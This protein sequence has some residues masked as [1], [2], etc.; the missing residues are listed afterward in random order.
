MQAA[1]G[2]A[3]SVVNAPFTQKRRQGETKRKKQ[4]VHRIHMRVEKENLLAVLRNHMAGLPL[5]SEIHLK[6]TRRY[7]KQKKI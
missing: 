7:L 5:Y 4:A 6:H 1:K 2:V 3:I